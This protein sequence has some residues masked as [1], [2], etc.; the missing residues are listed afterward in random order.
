[1]SARIFDKGGTMIEEG[2]SVAVGTESRSPRPAWPAVCALAVVLAAL[3]TV[4]ASATSLVNLLVNP[5]AEQQPVT[6]HGDASDSSVAPWRRRL[7]SALGRQLLLVG[8]V[9][10]RYLYQIVD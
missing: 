9:A 5:G 10:Q 1:M 3:G 2:V 6:S 8:T 7:E 4:R